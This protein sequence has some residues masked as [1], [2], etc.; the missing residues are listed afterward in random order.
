MKYK[1]AICC[2]TYNRKESLKRLLLS[3]SN[4]YYEDK[5]TLI[6]SIDKSDT[7][8][9]ELFADSYDWKFGEKR[10]IKHQ[11]NMG[12]RKH[13]LSCGD[14]LVEYDALIMLEDDISVSPSFYTFA[15]Q[16]VEAYYD[17]ND[18]AGI[19][20][21]SWAVNSQN[22]MPFCPIQSNS[23]VF[24]MQLAQSWGQIWM[25]NQWM[26]F[27]QWYNSPKVKF[28]ETS[29]LPRSICYW[30]E[31]SWLKY[32]IKYCIENNKWFIYPYISLSTNNSEVGTHYKD[33]NTI[34]QVPILTYDKRNF[35]LNISVKYDAFY[36]NESLYD[37]LNLSKNDLCI[38]LY[39]NKGN[40]EKKRYWLSCRKMG[41]KIIHTYGLNYKPI[42]MNVIHDEP[43]NSIFLYDTSVKKSNKIRFGNMAIFCYFYNYTNIYVHLK[44][45]IKYL[46]NYKQC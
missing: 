27:I 46:I 31:K 41:Y 34:F 1:I 11:Q 22:F 42:E 16:C 43:G 26:N 30:S 39:G 12:L 7:D 40:R 17:N 38:D 8:E 6:I 14:L 29:H 44:N 10:V 45:Y 24:M 35:N 20:L 18:I 25:K 28:A 15:S 37:I 21:Y 5:V 36:E 2:I 32:H 3:L 33:H 23:D 19:S 4:A 13:I 9:I